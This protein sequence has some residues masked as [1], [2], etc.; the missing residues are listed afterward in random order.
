MGGVALS[1]AQIAQLDISKEDMEKIL[2]PEQVE[3]A[4]TAKQKQVKQVSDEHLRYLILCNRPMM[5][6]EFTSPMEFICPMSQDVLKRLTE[7][8]PLEEVE[9]TLSEQQISTLTEK[10]LSGLKLTP[11]QCDVLGMVPGQ[12][13]QISEIA[14]ITLNGQ[15]VAITSSLTNTNTNILP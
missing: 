12:N 8:S 9:L 5:T 6:W 4:A 14:L 3:K 1:T 10:Q 11:E 7:N 13:I 2:E 15:Q